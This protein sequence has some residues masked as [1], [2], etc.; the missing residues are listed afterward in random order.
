MK[1]TLLPFLISFSLVFIF[2]L[3]FIRC[4]EESSTTLAPYE[5]QRN[6]EMLKVTLNYTP[7]IQ[8]LGGRVA[9]VGVN[10][11]KR[12][13]LD[14]SLVWL[15]TAQDNSI[16]SY[17]TVGENTDVDKILSCG[18]TPVDS[19][20]DETEYTFWVAEKAALDALFDSTAMSPEFFSDST[21]I[22]RFLLKGQ[23]GG[24]KDP[25]GDL[26]VQLK[27]FR[28]ETL[29]EDKYIID[30]TPNTI[31]FRRIAIREGSF[32]A[33]TE[34]IWHIV[35]PDGVPDNIYPPVVIGST[36]PGTDLAI[37]WPETGFESNTVY[38]VWMANSDWVINDFRPSAPGYA[39]YRIF[40]F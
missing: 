5:G 6:L 28:E 25:Q 39:W 33:F 10:K 38:F 29:M 40:A 16:S 31:P 22:L 23:F 14:T 4:T 11:G 17:V 12:A 3:T 20:Q 15:T 8:W 35:T 36:I 9:A 32:G 34:L 2:C 13:A 27:V 21:F 18:G 26:I 19:L 1:K 24:A 7:D 37:P 30:W